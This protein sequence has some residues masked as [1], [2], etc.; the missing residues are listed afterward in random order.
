MNKILEKQITQMAEIDRD[1]RLNA[2]QG[3]ELVNYLIYAVD[4]G[5]NQIIWRIIEQYGYPTKKM[6]GEKAMKA[7]WLLVQHQDYD[8]ELQKQ[9]LKNCDFD[10]EAAQHLT[11]RVLINSGEEQIYGTQH[12]RLANRKIVVAPIKKRT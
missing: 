9:C 1:L 11:D 6:V 5:H 2:K 3:K 4:I 7:F 10:A 8:V 12:K